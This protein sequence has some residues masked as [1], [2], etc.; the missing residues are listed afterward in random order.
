MT[1]SE[2]PLLV[3]DPSVGD[4]YKNWQRL[5][6]SLSAL[7]G[8]TVDRAILVQMPENVGIDVV[9]KFLQTNYQPQP[10]PE[11]PELFKTLS[12]L[13]LENFTSVSDYAHNFEA[14][15]NDMESLFPGKISILVVRTLFL[16]GLGKGWEE[17]KRTMLDANTGAPREPLTNLITDAQDF[18]KLFIIEQEVPTEQVDTRRARDVPTEQVETRRARD[19]PFCGY[20]NKIGHSQKSC[21][22]AKGRSKQEVQAVREQLKQDHRRKRNQQNE[23]NGQN[24]GSLSRRITRP[25]NIRGSAPN[26]IFKS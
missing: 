7:L 14:I 21:W 22:Y 4:S 17:F 1:G 25:L 13:R 15:Y 5:D 2:Q 3:L 18:E 11:Y 16:D 6:K 20:C 23:Q 9:Y 12:R 10:R 26:R 19:V 24:E 8:I